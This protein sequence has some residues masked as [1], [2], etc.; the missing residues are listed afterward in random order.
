MEKVLES[1]KVPISGGL[2]FIHNGKKVYLE[3]EKEIN[4]IWIIVYLFENKKMVLK[5]KVFVELS[6]LPKPD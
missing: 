2:S 4:G 6:T 1:K 5:K 3:V